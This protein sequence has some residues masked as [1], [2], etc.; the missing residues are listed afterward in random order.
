MPNECGWT[1]GPWA[2]QTLI[3]PDAVAIIEPKN[4]DSR[5]MSQKLI[6][7]V[8]SL[9]PGVMRANAQLI[10]AAPDL[11]SALFSLLELIHEDPET[12]PDYLREPARAALAKARGEKP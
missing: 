2:L 9:R 4:A 8:P 7:E 10:A 12:V 11:Y 6:A 1:P 5:T 3:N